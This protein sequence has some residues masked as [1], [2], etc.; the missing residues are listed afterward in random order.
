MLVIIV[1]CTPTLLDLICTGAPS[2]GDAQLPLPC[3]SRQPFHPRRLH[4]FMQTH[5]LVDE[6]TEET[7]DDGESD[8]GESLDG[9][10]PGDG[11]VDGHLGRG[12]DGRSKRLRVAAAVDMQPPE[13]ARQVGSQ[14]GGA[15]AKLQATAREGELRMMQEESRKKHAA[16]KAAFGQ[17]R[18]EDGKGQKKGS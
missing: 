9:T 4:A 10:P 3:R 13:H 12:A 1:S 8:G 14:V 2:E 17:V 18:G 11:D 16:L 6:S 15:V 5:F 7:D